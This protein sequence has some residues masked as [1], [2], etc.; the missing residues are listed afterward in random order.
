MRK[1]VGAVGV[2]VALMFLM[3]ATRAEASLVL[4]QSYTGNVG[5]ST[6]GWGGLD[7]NGVISALVPAGSTVIAAYLYTATFLN[8]THAGVDSTLNGADVT[9]GAPVENVTA[10]CDI[11]SARADVTSIVKPVIDAGPGGVYNFNITE[12]S[13]SQDGEAL[14]V[15]YSNP[16]LPVASV[17]I[18]DGFSAV[19]GDSFAINFADPLNPAAPGFFADMMLG[20]GFSCCNQRSNVTV[21]GT[22]ITQNAGNF[23]DGE[24]LADGS[25]I[26]V[27]SF[28]DLYS[29]HLPSYAQDHERYNLT[30]YVVAGDTTI[31]VETN[32]PS[33]DDNIFL[34]VFHVLGRAGFNQPPP[35]PPGPSA[36]EPMT[37][38]LLGVGATGLAVRRRYRRSAA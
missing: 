32:N 13:S 26:T 16:A 15:V 36:P 8:P 38:A 29:P 30:P 23:D 25:L 10:C 20:I 37:L 7:Q 18:L 17:G 21:E 14:V 33:N 9:Y 31:T 12:T 5:V 24:N 2:A 11:A 27:G 19:G 1:Q 3:G 6:D 35:P 28:D 34:A 4:F 22:L